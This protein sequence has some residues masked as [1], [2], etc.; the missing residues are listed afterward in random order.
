MDKA[1]L[2]GLGTGL[3]GFFILVIGGL[4]PAILFMMLV[5]GAA[6]VKHLSDTG[7]L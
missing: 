5:L 2:A 1:T 3:I 6:V 4:T 7:K